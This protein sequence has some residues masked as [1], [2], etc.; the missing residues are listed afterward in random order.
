[1]RRLSGVVFILLSI[2]ICMGKGMEG[3]AAEGGKQRQHLVY[4]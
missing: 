4:S 2:A 1:M 3:V